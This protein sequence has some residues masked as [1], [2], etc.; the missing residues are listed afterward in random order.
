MLWFFAIVAVLLAAACALYWRWRRRVEADIAE[1][2]AVEWARFQQNE[3]EF[4]KGLTEEKFREVYAR[5]HRPRF[6]GYALA[7][8]ATFFA[9]LPATF[10]ALTLALWGAEKTGLVPE[11]IDVANRLLLKNG[12]LV[13]FREAPPEAALYYIRDLA[14]FYYFFGVLVVWLL[15]VW[16]YMR[17]YHRRRPGYLRDEIIRARS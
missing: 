3:P 10:M 11:P 4:V 9:A 5:V 8:V 15:I 6:P 16:F 7:T 1:G 12:E 17:R 13:F 2:A 14:G